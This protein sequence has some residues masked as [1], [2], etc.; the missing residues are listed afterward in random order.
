MPILSRSLMTILMVSYAM[1]ALA[2]DAP[3]QRDATAATKQA[4]AAAA[5][6][7]PPPDPRDRDFAS[8]GFIATWPERIIR[9]D[10]GRPSMDLG[11][12]DF[13][14]GD[15]PDTVNPGLWRHNSVLRNEGLYEVVP[16]LYQVRNFDNSNISFV[17]TPNGWIVIDPLTVT[18]VARSSF[19]LLR[20]HVANK[21]VLAV[22]Y[23]HSHSDHFGGVAGVVDPADVAAGKVQIIAPE[24]FT[25]AVT[26]EWVMAGN[27]M[28]RRS[29][30]QFGLFLPRDP[31]GHVGMG[32]GTAIAAGEQNFI[33]PTREIS[34]TG[35]TVTIDGI[36]I[37][38]QMA[39]GTEA[40]VEFNF[41]I[42]ALK[43]LS[44]AE[45]ATSTLHNI[46]TL[47]GAEVRDAKAW[48]QALTEAQRMWG[49]KAQVLFASHHWPRFGNDTIRTYLAHQRDAYKYI[50]DQTVRR[51]NMGET[52]AEIAEHLR[53]PQALRDD[54]SVRGFYGTVSH[55][56]K[57]V[58][59]RYMGWYDGI[60]ANLNPHPPVARAKRLVDAL[61]GAEA[62]HRAAGAAFAAGDY[63]WSAELAHNGVFADPADMQSRRLLADSYEQLGYQ[64]ESAVWRNIYLTGARELRQ[65]P[66]AYPSA[67]PSA[68][69]QATPFGDL[70][71]FVATTLDPERAGDTRL[72]FNLV[73]A[74]DGKQFGVTLGN[75]V[76][77]SEA[78]HVIAGAPTL[79]APKPVL[80]GILY[81]Q[82]D[83][84]AAI[85]AGQASLT[86]EEAPIAQ[87]VAMLDMP[88][89]DFAIVEP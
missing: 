31:R 40:P 44:T 80:L 39:Q 33:P 17:E 84:N 34:H 37:V 87:L 54:W 57:A 26:S 41:Y 13:I 43:A 56:A 1:P 14:E 78:G 32:M 36:D 61:G 45:T 55:N 58:Y 79:T 12:N 86:G 53:L 29:F 77:V 82:L 85:G 72:A 68:L 62:L 73:T 64:T 23:T 51:M 11:G 21:P 6:D 69:A 47:R 49:D 71:D 22:I 46:Q 4:Q 65:G 2:Q 7:L 10:D 50:H 70:L 67:G 20:Q 59:D 63:R 60:P 16:G 3:L 81:G 24:G 30:Y 88:Q 48:A 89:L 74:G 76:L 28:G 9:Q 27:A 42:P 66:D 35:E 38:F 83:I 18:E 75:A 52:P 25:D 19:D 15:A 8:R 5:R